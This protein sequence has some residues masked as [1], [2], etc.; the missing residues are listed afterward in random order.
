VQYLTTEARAA[1]SDTD[2]TV[3]VVDRT[4]VGNVVR[5]KSH[6]GDRTA[7][8][9]VTGHQIG[10]IDDTGAYKP[11]LR[12]NGSGLGG[13][14]LSQ[15]FGLVRAKGQWRIDS[16]QPGLLVT[17]A[18]FEAFRQV[19]VYFF[20]SA[21]RNLVP[22]ARYT[23]LSAPTDLIRWLVTTELAQQPPQP[24]T[25]A[26]PQAGS[27]QVSTTV[28]ADPGAPNSPVTI[29]IPGASALDGT[30]LNRL[31]TQISATLKQVLQVDRIEITGGADPGCQQHHLHPGAAL[32]AVRTHP[33]GQPA[34][35]REGRRGLPGIRPT[36]PG[37]RGRGSLRPH[38]GR[39]DR[40]QGVGRAAGRRGSRHR[41]RRRARHLESEDTG[42][43]GRDHRARQ[44]VPP[45]LGSGHEGGLDR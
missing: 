22:E 24:L 7:K 23:Q 25:T 17:A 4:Q 8:I 5:G 11:F 18:Q 15:P 43:A 27:K 41:T 38:F 44:P 45:G 31:A 35:L 13:V 12:G 21:E 40:Y 19:A 3:T 9:T 2:T 37:T 36:D 39:A 34:L 6:N 33:A 16:L 29:E 26:V 28:P 20:D 42:G 10:T 1:W 30:N 14:P 32:R